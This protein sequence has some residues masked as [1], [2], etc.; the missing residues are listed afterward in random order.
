VNTCTLGGRGQGEHGSQEQL[1]P[2]PSKHTAELAKTKGLDVD[3]VSV[4]GDHF[5]SVPAAM[6]QSVQFFRQHP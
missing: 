2:V 6:Q 1:F 5:T 4:P 3:A